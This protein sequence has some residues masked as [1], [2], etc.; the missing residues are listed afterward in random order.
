[1]PRV[2]VIIP[3]YNQGRFVE[4]AIESVFAQ[5]YTDWE[6]VVVDDGSTD[7]TPERVQPHLPRL[8][9]VHQEHGGTPSAL[10]RAV[11]ASTGELVAWL[12]ADD[13]FLPRKLELQVAY[14][15]DVRRDR[16]ELGMVYTDF[17]FVGEDGAIRERVASPEYGS[18]QEWRRVLV[19]TG[20]PINGSTTLV[21]RACFE[22]VGLFDETLL[23]AHDY[24]LW[25]RLTGHYDFGHVREA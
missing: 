14:F 23:Q 1:M 6:L 7:D 20:C 4:E 19:A 11:R 2:S 3:V 22:K 17:F 10:N 25:I 5:T 8:R 16:P 13:A 12:S 24:D 18:R 15:D 21:H 9:Y